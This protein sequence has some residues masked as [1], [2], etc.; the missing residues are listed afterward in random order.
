MAA[1][2]HFLMTASLTGGSPNLGAQFLLRVGPAGS[3]LE[4]RRLDL[5]PP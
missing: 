4:P 2:T 1:A 3:G 5:G